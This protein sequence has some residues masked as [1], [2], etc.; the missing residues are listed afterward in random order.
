[1]KVHASNLELGSGENLASR[2]GRLTSKER[3]TSNHFTRPWVCSSAGLNTVAKRKVCLLRGTEHRS[4]NMYSVTVLIELC[5]LSTVSLSVFTFVVRNFVVIDM[6]FSKN[7]RQA[8]GI[9]TGCV[10]ELHFRV[11]PSWLR[12]RN[13]S[14]VFYQALYFYRCLC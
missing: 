4:S 12:I 6:N 9:L 2:P 7:M 3:A 11:G 5:W 10:R 8:E 13:K 1:M 14:R